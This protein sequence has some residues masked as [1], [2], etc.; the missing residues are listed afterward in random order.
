[1]D[2]FPLCI[3]TQDTDEI[4][5]FCRWVAPTFGAINLEDISAP[6]CFAVEEALKETL[7]IPVFHDDQHG[8]A[9]VVL[10]GIIN[11]LKLTGQKPEQ[12]KAVVAGAGAAGYACTRTLWEFGLKNVVV[13]DRQGAIGPAREFG[14]NPAKKWLAAH[15]NPEGLTGD[16]KAC[17]KGANLFLGV[18]GPGL[19]GRAD[20]ETMAEKP[21]IFAMSN[22]V[23]EVMPEEAED[24]CAVMATGR[25]DYPNQINNV[26]A[27][28]GIFRG[29]LDSRSRQIN[30]AM[31]QAAAHAIADIITDEELSAD[32]I[33]PS[34]FN[35]KVAKQV[36]A[37][38]ARAA[39]KTGVAR[40]L[41]K[42]I[43]LYS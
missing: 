26:L 22:P 40:R 36:A 38:V 10:A 25:S 42:A 24:L 8:T 28:P 13:C 31:K 4:I 18:S 17:L 12:L 27:F 19:L 16:L 39:H 14:D 37:A 21:I 1:V 30:E 11:A 34:V 23:P 2:S 9:V 41:S 6:R 32:Y 5:R 29:A 15:T 35:R 20:V 43:R 7:D 3:D 33:I